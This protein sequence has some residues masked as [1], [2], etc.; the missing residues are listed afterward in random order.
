MG[1]GLFSIL[2]AILNLLR[3]SFRSISFST[4][5]SFFCFVIRFYQL[6]AKARDRNILSALVHVCIQFRS[7]NLTM[8]H[9][10]LYRSDVVIHPV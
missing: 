9:I 1:F 10:L 8:P 7:R 6:L 4:N 3:F 5:F 2:A